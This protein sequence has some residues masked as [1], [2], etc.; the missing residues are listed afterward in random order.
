MISVDALKQTLCSTLCSSTEVTPVPSGFA[1]STIFQDRSG[2]L[3]DCYVVEDADGY[4]LEDDGEYLARLVASGVPI[5]QGQRG[6]LL[7]EILEQGGA[8]WD[9]D[10]YEIRS[11]SFGVAEI[12]P[13]LMNFVS[14]LIRIRDLELLSR[15][16]IRSTFR[17]DVLAKMHESFGPSAD[18]C[19][20]EAI[21]QKFH[22][23]PSDIVIRPTNPKSTRTGALFLVTSTDRLNEALLLKYEVERQDRQDV[24]VVALLEESD[25]RLISK[26]K[27]QRAQNRSLSMPIFRG[28]EEAAVARIGRELGL[29]DLVVS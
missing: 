29:P 4:R 3:I 11:I 16:F 10:S 14:S 17:E 8:Y 1:I 23:F 12:V 6:Q 18:F 9:P 19:E 25:M 5:D 24:N 28:D 15:E 22:E 13:K 27:F 21:D 7:R 26:K 20:N 2:D